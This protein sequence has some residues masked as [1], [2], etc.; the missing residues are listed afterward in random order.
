MHMHIT[1]VPFA[2]DAG[3][4]EPKGFSCL[5]TIIYRQSLSLI[6]PN[7]DHR[8]VLRCP[9]ARCCLR[10]ESVMA[11]PSKRVLIVDNNEEE[12]CVFV[13]MLERAGYETKTTWSGLEALELLKSEEFAILLVSNYL[14]DLY[15]GEFLERLKALPKQPCSI[16][17][18]ENQSRAS[19]LL[20]LKNMIEG[21]RLRP[22]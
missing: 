2:G 4:P 15:V 13:S 6:T 16:V 3:H 12:S 18:Q 7:C 19:T 21:E 10:R 22:S 14:P 20:K 9:I 17:I 11:S 1:G 5:R 8:H